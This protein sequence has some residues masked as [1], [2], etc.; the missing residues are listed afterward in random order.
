MKEG[1]AKWIVM[2]NSVDCPKNFFNI[3]KTSINSYYNP[4]N[5]FSMP[6]G[7]NF[8]LKRFLKAKSLHWVP[9]NLK[10]HKMLQQGSY[11]DYHAYI[12]CNEPEQAGWN[13]LIDYF[14]FTNKKEEKNKMST[15]LTKLN[16]DIFDTG[17]C[18]F[19]LMHKLLKNTYTQA[20]KNTEWK[21]RDLYQLY[22]A[23]FNSAFFINYPNPKSINV[24]YASNDFIDDTIDS[25]EV[26][27]YNNFKE[28]YKKILIKKKIKN[29]FIFKK[30]LS[31]FKKSK[32]FKFIFSFVYILL[33]L[34][35]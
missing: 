13:K 3:I 10:W 12:P 1:P 27:R 31:K 2:E 35:V 28:I 20:P 34:L 25:G 30:I 4:I 8:L 32:I 9:R 22:M 6:S 19:K 5:I 17:K 11:S 16:K 15:E 14:N 23:Y 33:T 21:N 24:F 18:S 26:S 7:P 29:Y